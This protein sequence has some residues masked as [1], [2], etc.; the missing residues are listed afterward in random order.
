VIATWTKN[1][2]EQLIERDLPLL[3][4]VLGLPFDAALVQGRE[5]YVCRRR[6]EQSLRQGDLTFENAR[7]AAELRSVVAWSAQSVVGT[8]ASLD[9]EPRAE[10]WAAVRAER[11]NCLQ[12]KSPFYRNCVWQQAK[13]RAR[14]AS[15]LV[16]NHALLLADLKLKRGGGSVLPPY[17]MLIV[18][19]A[20]HLEEVAAEHLGA[21]VARGTVLGLLKAAARAADAAGNAPRSGFDGVLQRSRVAAVEL[22]ERVTQWLAARTSAALDASAAL[23]RD[24]PLLL[25]ELHDRMHELAARAKGESA[26]G[27]L[28]AR[29]TSALDLADQ[30]EKILAGDAANVIA[31]AERGDE[32]GDA[33][34]CSAPIEPGPI[35]AAELFAP[36]HAAVL[37]S[38]TLAVAPPP[39]R[40]SW[41][42][43]GTG[44]RDATTRMLQSPFDYR[45]QARLVIDPLPEPTDARA[46]IASMIERVPFH[47]RR[48]EGRAFVL[49]T[50]RKTMEEV[51]EGSRAEIERA[52][53]RLLVQG[54]DKPRSALLD[55]FRRG[56]PAALFGLA[57]FWE[58]VD[59]P[60]SELTHVILTRLPFPVPD[61]PLEKARAERL[62]KEGRDPFALLSL[63]K[64]VLRF[65]QGFG[66]LIRRKDDH[67]FVT[68]LDARLIQRR[69]GRVFLDALPDCPKVV[70]HDGEEIP[71]DEEGREG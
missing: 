21:R 32:R 18:D 4:E 57:S 61:H 48:T 60:G 40:F 14:D 24:L 15:V 59:V 44:V 45:R 49:F 65:K 2:Q 70:L 35:L 55:E 71:L 30:F 47:V 67:G 54:R 20:H 68:V 11:G 8:R 37:T 27:E 33:A 50:S 3:R 12:A 22:F 19:E 41:L 64:A 42:A 26:Q 58:G 36:L 5:N 17:S 9:F 7:A 52:G 66:R 28:V 53:I 39:D 69:Y 10:V 1:L 56:Q 63:P 38:A 25:R 34:L 6:A 51:A 43:R 23:P 62:K 31:Y 46:W 13:R 29:A 16:V